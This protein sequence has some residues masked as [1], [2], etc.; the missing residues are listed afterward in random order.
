M[1]TIKNISKLV[2][3]E[4]HPWKIEYI[5][6]FE[7]SYIISVENIGD[8]VLF[9][10]NVFLNRIPEEVDGNKLYSLKLMGDETLLPASLLSSPK[11]LGK[12]IINLLNML[13]YK[14]Q[15]TPF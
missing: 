6:E 2:G 7:Y 11:I 8:G 13:D 12:H 3:Y 10:T 15:N 5:N 1:L 14:A 9:M 4:S